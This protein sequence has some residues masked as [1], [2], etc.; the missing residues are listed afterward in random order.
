MTNA[1][2]AAGALGRLVFFCLDT[3]DSAARLGGCLR[4]IRC[5]ELSCLLSPKVSEGEE[6]LTLFTLLMMGGN[7]ALIDVY[8]HVYVLA[9]TLS[10][11]VRQHDL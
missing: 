9:A 8:T 4:A 11:E 6:G 2:A 3:M 1:S 7:H 10:E 5:V